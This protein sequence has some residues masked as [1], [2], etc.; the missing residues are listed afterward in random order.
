V[1]QESFHT[2]F[3]LVHGQLHRLAIYFAMEQ[4]CRFP[5]LPHIV[6]SEKVP[7][8]NL[9]LPPL[10]STV[11]EMSQAN[12][13][14]SSRYH[15]APADRAS[16]DD[17]AHEDERLIVTLDEPELQPPRGKTYLTIH[18]TFWI[19]VDSVLLCLAAF[20]IL[21]QVPDPEFGGV[22]PSIV[23]L[24]VSFVWNILVLICPPR[25]SLIRFK[26]ELGTSPG[27]TA[28]PPT[29]N[30]GRGTI[31]WGINLVLEIALIIGAIASFIIVSAVGWPRQNRRICNSKG[32]QNVSG[33]I[34]PI[35]TAAFILGAVG[36]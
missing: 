17:D 8:N 3:S 16:I 15:I 26:S 31:W 36:M 13:N 11:P 29:S 2:L 18:P 23:F 33:P 7:H 20:I 35:F 4:K 10:Y 12:R 34:S 32:C 28:S 27:L 6:Y 1:E 19:R 21:V 25:K 9:A 22:I 24:I 5:N 14:S 30:K